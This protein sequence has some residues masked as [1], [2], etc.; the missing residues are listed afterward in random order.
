MWKCLCE[1]G[2]ST[3][4]R[5]A[6][7]RGGGVKSCGCLQIEFASKLYK[8]VFG[9]KHPSYGMTHTE[10]AKK[11]MSLNHADFSGEKHPKYGT[12][13][14]EETRKKMSDNHADFRGSKGPNWKG[15]ITS[16]RVK[17]MSSSEYKYWRNQVFGRDYY[18][19]QICNKQGGKLQAHHILPWAKY[20]GLIKYNISNGITLCIDC[21]RT[22]NG[23]EMQFTRFLIRMNVEKEA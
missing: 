20:N 19:C 9:E 22:I 1:C 13:H 7:L 17:D 16:E 18:T 2:N 3:F 15:G 6:T 4:V 11:K 23:Y 5:C 8:G 10:E 14:S 21:H 12:A